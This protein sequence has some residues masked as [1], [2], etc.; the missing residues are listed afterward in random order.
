LIR[1]GRSCES[2][3]EKLADFLDTYLEAVAAVSPQWF[4]GSAERMAAV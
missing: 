3:T 1:F 4:D 2:A